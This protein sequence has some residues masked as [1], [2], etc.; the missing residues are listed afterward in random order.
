MFLTSILHNAVSSLP[1]RAT[2]MTTTQPTTDRM[3]WSF[4]ILPPPP[5]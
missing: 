2:A 1:R 5:A 3:I 4:K